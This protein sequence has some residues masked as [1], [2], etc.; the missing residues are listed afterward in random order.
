MFLYTIMK[1]II[2]PYVTMSLDVKQYANV[3]NVRYLKI[4]IAENKDRHFDTYPHQFY[5]D[6]GHKDLIE[7]HIF[8][9]HPG[10]RR[11]R[12]FTI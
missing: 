9:I 3:L 6:R 2:I 11:I 10:C 5:I 8:S 4:F 1:V 7:I 12:R